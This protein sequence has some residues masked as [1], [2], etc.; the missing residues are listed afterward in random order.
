MKENKQLKGKKEKRKDTVRGKKWW[1]ERWLSMVLVRMRREHKLER[2]KKTA[3][4]KDK[5]E[6]YIWQEVL[7]EGKEGGHQRWGLR[8]NK[9]RKGQG[10]IKKKRERKKEEWEIKWLQIR[11]KGADE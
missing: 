3:K 10:L 2:Q 9:R 7:L 5:R 11:A 8:A 1:K 6:K 4:L